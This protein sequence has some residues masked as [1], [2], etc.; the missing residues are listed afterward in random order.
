[1]NTGQEESR[2]ARVEYDGLGI[3]RLRFHAGTRLDA[4]AFIELQQARERLTHGARHAVIALVPD[5]FDFDISVMYNDHYDGN[6]AAAFTA[7]MAVVTNDSSHQRILAVYCNYF[8]PP[9]PVQ[10]FGDETDAAAWAQAM[11]A[12]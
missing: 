8:P 1:M 2:V 4:A 12:G 10:A 6:A 7:A 3:V 11:V 9:F 5:D